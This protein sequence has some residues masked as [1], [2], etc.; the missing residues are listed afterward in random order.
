MNKIYMN[1][2]GMGDIQR[3]LKELSR[4]L[5]GSGYV[6]IGV[7]GANS[8]KSREGVTMGEIAVKNEFG[9]KSERIPARSFIRMPV[10]HQSEK[11]VKGLYNV[12][13]KQKKDTK[14]ILKKLLTRLGILSEK[15][16]QEAFAT[17]GFG[18]WKPNAPLTIA[19]KGS[20][21]PLI[22]TGELRKSVTSEVF[23]DG[24]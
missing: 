24:K 22:D 10:E 4:D 23:L 5:K 20:D 17:R 19:L 7:L 12:R 9:S 15:A 2:K 3:T 8:G 16:I 18:Q 11:I 13:L 1:V 14:N 6:K 21:S